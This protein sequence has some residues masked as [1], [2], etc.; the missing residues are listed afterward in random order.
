LI[1][2][3]LDRRKLLAFL[4]FI[5]EFCLGCRIQRPKKMPEM[6]T[7]NMAEA[8]GAQRQW[9]SFLD[10]NQ[11]IIVQVTTRSSRVFQRQCYRNPEIQRVEHLFLAA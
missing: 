5:L 1:P 10:R 3:N 9:R 6:D 11:S 4:A 8:E 2:L 7:S